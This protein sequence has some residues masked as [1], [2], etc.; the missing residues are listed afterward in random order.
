VGEH[1]NASRS[2]SLLSIALCRPLLVAGE[3]AVSVNRRIRWVL[4]LIG[5]SFVFGCT[6]DTPPSVTEV[7]IV[8]TNTLDVVVFCSDTKQAPVVVTETDTEVRVTV[9][10]AAPD[11]NCVTA[12]NVTLNAPLGTRALLD[13]NNGTALAVHGDWRCGEPGD[14]VGRCDGIDTPAPGR[15]NTYE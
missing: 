15:P 10:N 7:S 2:I 13:G 11:F 1:D 4:G 12:V 14:T 9:T 8:T 3:A 5:A 6:P